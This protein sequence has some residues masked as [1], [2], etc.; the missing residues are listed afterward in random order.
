[1][2]TSLVEVWTFIAPHSGLNASMA[3]KHSYKQIWTLKSS[4]SCV[5][6]REFL[7]LSRATVC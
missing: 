4:D 3:S 7:I 5:K 6:S 2:M 1:M